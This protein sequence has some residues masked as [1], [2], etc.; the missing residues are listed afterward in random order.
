MSGRKTIGTIKMRN[1]QV[2]DSLKGLGTRIYDQIEDRKFPWVDIKSRTSQN[3]KMDEKLGQYVL[4]PKTIKRSAHNR[5]NLKPL[6]Q[7]LWVSTVGKE[8]LE[9][10]KTSTLR[11][12]FYMAQGEGTE[13]QFAEQSES[14]DIITDL[15]TVLNAARED[16]HIYPKERSAIFGD[17]TV[18]YT[19]PPG[20]EGQKRNMALD[21]NGTVI[22]PPMTS[23]EFV[24]CQADKLIVVE[25]HAMFTRFIEEGAYKKFNALLISSEG[26]APR[27][28]RKLI[29]RLST[30]LDLP[31]MI[32][33]D[34]D[35]WGISIASVIIHGSVNC[36]HLRDLNTPEAVWAGI[37]ASDIVKY[38]LPTVRMTDRTMQKR[39]SD[40]EKLDKLAQFFDTPAFKNTVWQKEI[41]LYEKLKRKC[42][43]EAF[44][45]Y[46][47][48][49]VVDKYLKDKIKEI[50]FS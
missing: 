8:L 9:Q 13:I 11:D 2:T 47:L 26:Q 14:D 29:R 45:R 25:K 6:S 32:L 49:F 43:L 1:R 41:A 31:V 44:S 46:G 10:N 33:T 23:A 15:E 50:G 24:K 17:L 30:E 22:G 12:V 19:S 42:E 27:A 3:I 4:G 37:Y 39:G 20:W 40:V 48:S 35:P 28:T 5:R 18:E 21:P 38:K 16:L 34:G 7:I 36:A